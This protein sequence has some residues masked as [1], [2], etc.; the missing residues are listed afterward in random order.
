MAG[1]NLE[2]D[3]C[4]KTF[5]LDAGVSDIDGTFCG[6]CY[7]AKR[8]NA[9]ADLGIDVGDDIILEDHVN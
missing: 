6:N 2:C 5:A 3:Y 1:M 4:G 7:T 8:D 9:E